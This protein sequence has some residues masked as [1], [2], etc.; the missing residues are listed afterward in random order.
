MDL[1]NH[2]NS[3]HTEEM[4]LD[5]MSMD[6]FRFVRDRNIE[7]F[8]LLGFSLGGKVAMNCAL[9]GS[10]SFGSR[11]D[12]A[13]QRQIMRELSLRIRSLV[14]G[15]IAPVRYEG[16]DWA[17]PATVRALQD[18]DLTALRSRTD[19]DA[20]L[21][22]TEKDP[23]VRL[24]LLTNLMQHHDQRNCSSNNSAE[25]EDA[26]PTFTWRMNLDSIARNLDKLADFPEGLPLETF[27]KPALFIQGG[28]SNLLRETYHERVRSLFPNS[29]IVKFEHSG[30]WVHNAEPER[31]SNTVKEFITERSR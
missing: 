7:R 18:I 17:I 15:D 10:G 30:H 22:K 19:A 5:S 27:E 21:L 6:V 29:R 4:D 20:L 28:L 2:G 1:R 8:D 9:G 14:V 24:F 11:G 12:N 16:K 23:N 3:P 13:G 26:R 31:F 25:E